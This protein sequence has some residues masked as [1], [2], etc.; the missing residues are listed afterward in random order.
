MPDAVCTGLCSLS[1]SG[2]T[3]DSRKVV[4]GS[5]FICLKGA[6]FDG[7]DFALQAVKLGTAALVV[8]QGALDALGVSI[9]D[10]ICVITVPDTRKALPIIAC[11]FFD[12]PSHHLTM[13]GITGTNG[14]TTTALMIAAILRGA[15]RSVGVIG[16]LGAEIDGV[17]LE[18]EHTTPEADQLQ[19]LLSRMKYQGADAAVME[20]SSHAIDQDRTAGI[21]FN[22]AVFTNITQD[23]L[24]Y[25]KTMEAYFDTK[26]RL[27]AEYPIRY[28]R[29]DGKTFLSVI[30]VVQWEGREL[31]TLARGEIVTF[32]TTDTPG[33]LTV[34]DVALTAESS[35]FILIY[36]DGTKRYE[37]P[38][39]LAVGGAFQVSNALGAAACC[40]R[41][42]IPI[43]KV[44]AGLASMKA[45]PGRFESI[46][47]GSPG[48]SVIVDYA[49]T[50]DGLDNLLRSAR[51]LKPSRLIT[52]FGCGGNRDRTKRPKMGRLA[53]TLSDVTIV[54]S[55]NPRH[56]N[57][58]E[59]I[60]EV[61]AGMDSAVDNNIVAKVLVHPNRREAIEFAIRSAMPGDIVLI[62]GKGH[63]D[64]QIVG[65]EVLPFDDRLVAGEILQQLEDEKN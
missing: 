14:K 8:N 13:I 42:G 45:V 59:I 47:V 35:R 40:V 27:F 36:D 6:Q 39:E 29:L 22:A 24:D 10:D 7:H 48:F 5:L 60:A 44:A 4:K 2:I 52:V 49:H 61:L 63:E 34:R 3:H 56:E 53:G 37:Y 55:D 62:A 50:P 31:V 51:S 65:D 15:G 23:H 58:G 26:A 18:S 30:N 20:V 32:S 19:A 54:T 9:P 1:I 43:E 33:V 46:R 12:Q 25:H 17:R 21:A 64:Y 41:L 28:P 38:I 16:T 11:A 57:P